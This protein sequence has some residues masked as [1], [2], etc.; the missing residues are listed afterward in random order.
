MINVMKRIEVWGDSVLKGVIYDDIRKK[1]RRIENRLAIDKIT[2]LGL[3]IR[4]NSKFGMTAPK[5][6]NLMLSAL[7]KG[8]DAEAAIIEFGGNDCDFKW[9]EVAA[10]PE[11]EHLPKTPLS[12]FKEC[13]TDMVKA[14][15]QSGIKPI[16]VNLPPIHSEKYFNWI[17]RSLDAG[18]ILKW[19]GDKELI[20]RHHETYSL[21]VVS[22]AQSLSCSFIDVRQP[23][24]LKRDY[25]NLLCED[26]IHPNEKGHELL[27]QTF[28]SYAKSIMYKLN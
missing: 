13:I 21:A 10:Q 16:L 11:K 7:K 18:A 23:F 8:I 5:A 27:S 19:L 12:V 28:E 24:L 22:L 25:F 2:G 9:A 15:R 4:N 20:Y 17:S 14:L 1:Y 6:R 3:D 26:G